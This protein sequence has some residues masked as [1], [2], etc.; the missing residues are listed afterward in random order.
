MSKTDRQKNNPH[1]KFNPEA[2]TAIAGV[3]IQSYTGIEL[4]LVTAIGCCDHYVNMSLYPDNN[5]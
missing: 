3:L 2:T 4:A 5:L 1:P